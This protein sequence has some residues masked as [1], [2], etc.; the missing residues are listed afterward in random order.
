[1]TTGGAPSVSAVVVNHR[2]AAECAECIGS[3]RASFAEARTD[4]EIVLV[5]CASGPEE[6][7]RLSILGADVFLPL[8]ENRGYSGGIN[9]GLARASSDRLLLCNADV[10]LLPG[11]LPPLL[12]AIAEPSVGAAAPLAFWDS[13]RRL[14][15]PPGDPLE[16]VRELARLAAGRFP[17]LDA[18][19]FAAFGRESLVLWRSG[20]AARHLIGAVLAARRD[21]FDRVGRFDERFPFEYEETE[22]EDRVRRRGLELRFVVE[23]Q[24]RHLW[25]VSASRSPE[26]GTRRRLSRA[27]YWERRY[28]RLG[29]A[30]LE[31][32]SARPGPLPPVR[33]LEWPSVPAR[34]GAWLAISPNPALFPFAGT[35]LADDFDL[36]GEIS[37]SLPSGR[38][39]FCVF[40]EANGHP[41]ETYVWEKAA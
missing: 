17:A 4:G 14:R 34:P 24:I 19:Q 20:G 39:F 25:S 41:L 29:R 38:L 36:P 12:A 16:F 9:A 27:N 26:T 28:G 18:R 30:I 22:W 40:S 2:S 31:A 8:S 3:L 5:D 6:A 13:G 11:A 10:M 23:S 15:L 33:R 21:V 1:V 35:P 7:E 32:V 37:A